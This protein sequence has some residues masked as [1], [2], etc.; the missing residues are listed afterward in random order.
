[1]FILLS[2]AERG[3]VVVDG[4]I[5]VFNARVA[6]YLWSCFA[7]WREGSE[8]YAMVLGDVVSSARRRFSQER[9]EV[10]VFTASFTLEPLV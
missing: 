8:V 10:I 1:M 9:K 6:V 5:G 2:S 7:L 4:S 3:D